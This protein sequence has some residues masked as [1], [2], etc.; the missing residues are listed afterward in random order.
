MWLA[1]LRNQIRPADL[2]L[3]L[4]VLVLIVASYRHFSHTDIPKKVYIYKD[5]KLEGV[6]PLSG[7][8]IMEI[9]EHN[10]IEI[11]HGRVRMVKAD[12][13]DKRCVKQGWSSGMPIICLPN[14]L[15]VE[16][17]S[18]ETDQKLILH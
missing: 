2:L 13:H 14:H 6:Y 8:Q 1:Q 18:N 4:I 7:K 3:I 10:T 9:D 5:N 16:I 12:C 17:K 15:V 11:A